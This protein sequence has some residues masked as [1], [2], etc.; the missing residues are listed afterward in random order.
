MANIWLD[1]G[2]TAVV[3][4][5]LIPAALTTTTNGSTVDL[6]DSNTNMASALL[7]VGAVSGTQGTCDVKIQESTAT[8]TGFTDITGASFT[9]VTT[10]GVAGTSGAQIISFQRQK[11]Y[12]RAYAT[13]GGTFTNML[14]GCSI[15]SQ[16]ATTPG[17]EGGWQNEQGAS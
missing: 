10:S 3:V 4:P 5:S 15:F 7:S 6:I 17:N 2:N 12:V 9:Q 1:I 11:R 8:N 13:F 16:R 14:I